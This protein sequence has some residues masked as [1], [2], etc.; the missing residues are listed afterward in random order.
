MET[1]NNHEGLMKNMP[2]PVK[3]R[4]SGQR[5]GPTWALAGPCLRGTW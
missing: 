1:E 3:S 2:T 5:T 4:I